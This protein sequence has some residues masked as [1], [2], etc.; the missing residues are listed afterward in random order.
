MSLLPH[1]INLQDDSPPSYTVSEIPGP[2]NLANL[3]RPVPNAQPCNFVSISRRD[4]SIKGTWL[5]DPMLSIPADLLP[6]LPEEESENTRTNLSLRTKDGSINANIFVL[7]TTAE[8]LQKAED[9]MPLRTLIDTS[10]KDGH[11]TINMVSSVF[12]RVWF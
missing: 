2:S 6:P 9:R 4:S 1:L 3:N 12:W 11:V 10:T 5:L 7:L 8:E